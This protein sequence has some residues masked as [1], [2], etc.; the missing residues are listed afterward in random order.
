MSLAL[1]AIGL[2]MLAQLVNAQELPSLIN[3]VDFSK[4]LPLLPNA[5]AGWTAD[6]PEGSTTDAGGFKLTNV[7]RDYRKGEGDNAP[8]TS[9]SILDSAAN[10]DYV[11][12][13]TAGW[14][15]T[16][17]S[18]D[19]YSKGVTVD[20]NQGF[21][22]FENDGKHGTLWLMVAKRYF[23][24]VETKGQDSAALQE[25]VRRI[26]LKKLAEVK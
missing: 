16:T 1:V 17:S 21:E 23:V 22:T 20:G 5:P 11:E 26:D 3:V 8:S 9:L 13:T 24:Q 18:T 15:F 6:K 14:N 25:W 12:T 19:G 4:L 10:P 2:S 7:H